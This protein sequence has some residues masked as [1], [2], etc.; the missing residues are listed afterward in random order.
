MIGGLNLQREL[1]D[2]R[3]HLYV[4]VVYIA[5]CIIVPGAY[6]PLKYAPDS[7]YYKL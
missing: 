1:M 5:T 4:H 3:S 6:E 7:T 2:F